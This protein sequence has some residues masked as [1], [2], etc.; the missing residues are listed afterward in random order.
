MILAFP[1][2]DCTPLEVLPEET[3]PIYPD[4]PPPP[5]SEKSPVAW[6]E[7]PPKYPPPPPPVPSHPLSARVPVLPFW[8]FPKANPEV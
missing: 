7:Y 5:A 4:P 3:P 2:P 6:L 8:P 1:F